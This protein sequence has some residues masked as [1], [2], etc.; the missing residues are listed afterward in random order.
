MKFVK[1]SFL[2]FCFSA[3]YGV[4]AQTADTSQVVPL[5][6]VSVTEKTQNRTQRSTSPLQ[7]LNNESLH[8]RNALQVSDAVKFFSGVTVKD[9]GGIG[10]LKTVSVR[11]LGATHTLVSYDG[12]ALSD[13]QTGQIDIGRFSLENVDMLSLANGQTDNIFCP[14]RMFSAA[15]MLNIR[16][17]VPSFSDNKPIN[18]KISLKTGS[19]A[20]I[21]PAF[22]LNTK[23]SEK[24]V[25]TFNGEYLSAKGNYPFRLYYGEKDDSVSIEKRQNSDVKNFRLESAFYAKFNENSSANLKAYFYNSERGLPGAVVFYNSVA[26]SSQ[27]VWDNDFF[28]QGNFTRKISQK[29][30]FQLNAKYNNAMMHYLDTA[31]LNDQHK[32]E[33]L[34]RQQQFYISAATQYKLNRHFSFSLATDVA[35]TSLTGKFESDTLTRSFARPVRYEFLTVAAAKYV[36]EHITATA[37]ALYTFVAETV[38]N[39]EPPP[40]KYRLSPYIGASYKPF[41]NYDFRLRAFYKNIFRLPTFNDLYYARVGNVNLKPEDTDQ[42]NIGATASTKITAWFPN[43]SFTIDAYRNNVKNKIVAIPSQN[44]LLWSMVNYGKVQVTGIDFVA[45]V[46]TKP[47]KDINVLLSSTYTYQRA[48]DADMASATFL[49]QIPYTP[50]VSGSGAVAVQTPW[51]NASCT[52]VWSGAR[53]AKYQNYSEN[54]LPPYTDNSI[55]ASKNFIL[56]D[57]TLNINVEVLNFT[58]R[59]Y[60]VVQW[61]PMPG[62]SVRVAVKYGF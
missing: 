12:I 21:N 58:N 61:F 20:L 52:L 15:A 24:Y 62:R 60:D 55:S 39:G 31:F 25:L 54:R 40:N 59:N 13:V 23:I 37:S 38:K 18:G 26:Y 34:F 48:L 30:D 57:K 11:G 33:S 47:A 22:S 4:M 56:K 29:F 7:V 8:R 19:F 5:Q 9:Y 28:I 35:L 49:H 43:L 3:F 17:N 46:E 14:A 1:L 45:N 16:T 53:Y 32:L 36:S 50:R 42:F 10:G 44:I 6:E 41:A 27:R 51:I 2:F